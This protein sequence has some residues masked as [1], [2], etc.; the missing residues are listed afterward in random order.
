MTAGDVTTGAAGTPGTVG[1][2]APSW[3]LRVALAL[4]CAGTVAATA[5]WTSASPAAL[6]VLGALALGTAIAPGTHL[7]TALLTCCALAVLVDADG[8]TWWTALLVLGVHA[9]HVLAA[10]AAVVP[11]SAS[12]E[13]VALRPSFERFVMVQAGAQLLVL[14]AWLVSPT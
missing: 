10:L 4:V 7:P 8:V 3:V 11:W 13:R 14:L 9:V 6:V 2:S 1:A 12:V 5:A